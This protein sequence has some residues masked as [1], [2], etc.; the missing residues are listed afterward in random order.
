MCLHSFGF[1]SFLT[2]HGGWRLFTSTVSK[3]ALNTKCERWSHTRIT[4]DL[5]RHAFRSYF[6]RFAINGDVLSELF[7][8]QSEMWIFFIFTYR[9]RMA[10]DVISLFCG[11]T[12]E[13][14]KKCWDFILC[15][16]FML[17]RSYGKVSESYFWIKNLFMQMKSMFSNQFYNK[18]ESEFLFFFYSVC[19]LKNVL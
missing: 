14:F 4:P 19:R 12:T 1:L 6:V 17:M 8:F 16:A 7:Q 10:T 11:V 5:S 15:I 18:I 2:Y 13:S 9:S 3:L